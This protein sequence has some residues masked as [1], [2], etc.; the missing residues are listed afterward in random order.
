MRSPNQTLETNCRPASPLDAGR[1]FGLAVHARSCVSG[2]SRSAFR[3]AANFMK[4]TAPMLLVIV[5]SGC[6]ATI[7]EVS[8]TAYSN[9]YKNNLWIRVNTR[10]GLFRGRENLLNFRRCNYSFSMT[11]KS[12][13]YTQDDMNVRILPSDSESGFKPKSALVKIMKVD[14]K[15][16]LVDIAVD[17]DRLPKLINGTYK[18]KVAEETADHVWYGRK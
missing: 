9:R 13:R 12:N 5:L 15:R 8:Y 18:L 6:V 10:E 17:D 1:R 4:H 14:A 11:T 3:Y 2:G 16:I 7:D